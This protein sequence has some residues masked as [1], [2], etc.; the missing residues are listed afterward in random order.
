[1]VPGLF[2]AFEAP[3]VDRIIESEADHARFM[4]ELVAWE[5]IMREPER[6]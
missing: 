1:M 6:L 5:V 3:V 4:A 2:A